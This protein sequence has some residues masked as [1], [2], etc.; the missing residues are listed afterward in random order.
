M[1]RNQD[2]ENINKYIKSR[3]IPVP[4]G[5]RRLSLLDFRHSAHEGGK[6]VSPLT[7]MNIPVTHFCYTLN[8]SRAKARPQDYV[9]EKFH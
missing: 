4:E 2:A 1:P 8:R 6:F 3:A 7:P 9:N 5:S